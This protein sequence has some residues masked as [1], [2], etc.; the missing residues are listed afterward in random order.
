MEC[1]HDSLKRIVCSKAPARFVLTALSKQA[2]SD[3][4]FAAGSCDW[5]SGCC[6]VDSAAGLVSEVGQVEAGAAWRGSET[7]QNARTTTAEALA[8]TAGWQ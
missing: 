7:A 4:R 1:M 3:S 6:T 8:A 2:E 5:H